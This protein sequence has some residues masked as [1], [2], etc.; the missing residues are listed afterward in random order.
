MKIFCVGRNYAKHAKEM[1]S[2]VPESPVIFMKPKTAILANGFT[3]YYPDFSNNIHYE[4]EIVYRISKSC[5]SLPR[6]RVKD[7]IDGIS[8]GIDFTARDLQAEYKAAGLPWELA[9]SFDFSAAIG[10]FV[11]MDFE[12]MLT[13]EIKLLKN[14]ELL[15]QG[16][17][18]DMIFPIDHIVSYISHR[19][20]LHKGD[21]IYSGTPEGV[22]P[23]APGDIL[24]LF[25]NDEKLLVTD[26]K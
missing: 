8:V 10:D 9:K 12:D 7:F 17:T 1:N 14:G 13:A 20:T 16:H 2:S 24:E 23:V 19:F 6:E 22:G 21:L 25:L 4:G 3:F 18:S 15:Q 11:S 5:K 26:I